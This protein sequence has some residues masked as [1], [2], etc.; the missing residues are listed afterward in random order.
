MSS[1]WQLRVRT[2]KLSFCITNGLRSDFSQIHFLIVFLCE[3]SFM[4]T[5]ST[6]FFSSTSKWVHLIWGLRKTA[7]ETFYF[8]WTTLLITYTSGSNSYICFSLCI[9]IYCFVCQY[10]LH[11][12][13]YHYNQNQPSVMFCKKGVLTNSAKLT[14][15]NQLRDSGTDV[16]LWILQNFSINL[17]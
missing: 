5:L 4:I 6:L 2:T 9:I 3:Y 1:V 17:F 10:F 7:S 8:T 12:Y 14:R 16:F 13:W 15:K 11:F